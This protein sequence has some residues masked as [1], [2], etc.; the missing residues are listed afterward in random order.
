MM[1]PTSFVHGF[2]LVAVPAFEGKA[3]M[4]FCGSPLLPSLLGVKRTWPIALHMSAFDPKRTFR[5]NKASLLV[6]PP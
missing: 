4:T 2:E 3:D 5:G 1:G 6:F